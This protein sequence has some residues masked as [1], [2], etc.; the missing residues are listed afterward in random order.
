VGPSVVVLDTGMAK[1]L[2]TTTMQHD[3]YAVFFHQQGLMAGA[4]IQGT[5]ITRIDR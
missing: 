2:T 3:I 4:G 1:A 5:K